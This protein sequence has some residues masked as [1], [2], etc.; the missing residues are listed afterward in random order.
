MKTT[1]NIEDKLIKNAREL[2][3]IKKKTSLIKFGL[4]ALIT[5]ESSKRLAKSG[6]TEKT[7]KITPRRRM[8]GK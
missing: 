2:T 4:Q 3:G 8:G 6:K 7:L 5:K 1:I